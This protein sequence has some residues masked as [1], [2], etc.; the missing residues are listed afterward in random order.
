MSSKLTKRLLQELTDYN[1]SSSSS[2]AERRSSG[3]VHL[4]PDSDGDLLSWTA[5]ISGPEDGPFAGGSL[6][7]LEDLVCDSQI[8]Q[9]KVI[10]AVMSVC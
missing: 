4:G 7:V 2:A 6:V 1:S 10:G 9:R 5:I 3:L 8:V